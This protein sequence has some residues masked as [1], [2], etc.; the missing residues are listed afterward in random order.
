MRN[1]TVFSTTLVLALA[2]VGAA[3]A[4]TLGAPA[5]HAALQRQVAVAP[6]VAVT[7]PTVI[8]TG[9]RETRVAVDTAA[10]ARTVV[11]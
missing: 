4:G 10:P 5:G 3:A 8:V 6:P 7:L 11:Q 1:D 2:V 9:K